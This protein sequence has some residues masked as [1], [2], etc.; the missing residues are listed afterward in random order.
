MW[1]P[2]CVYRCSV[3]RATGCVCVCDMGD[4][5]RP[6]IIFCEF[7]SFYTHSLSKLS[8][9]CNISFPVLHPL[10]ITRRIC[11]LWRV[12]II[13][14][15][16]Y[17]ILLL[18]FLQ[19]TLKVPIYFH[20]SVFSHFHWELF[21]HKILTVCCCMV[22]YVMDVAKNILGTIDEGRHFFN[23]HVHKWTKSIIYEDCYNILFTVP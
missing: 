23:R 19:T 17:F 9:F 5:C 20:K 4:S 3:M 18:F 2:I 22:C 10:I 21:N 14:K 11:K 16:S 15:N 8:K 13:L 6:C 12:F 1:T 7:S